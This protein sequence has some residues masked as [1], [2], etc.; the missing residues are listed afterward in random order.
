MQSNSG[1]IYAQVSFNQIKRNRRNFSHSTSCQ[2]LTNLSTGYAVF[3]HGAME[4]ADIS[5]Q[6]YNFPKTDYTTVEFLALE[7]WTSDDAKKKVQ[8]PLFSSPLFNFSYYY[9]NFSLFHFP[10]ITQTIAIS[11]K[12]SSHWRE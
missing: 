3:F 6:I 8:F 1:E 2:Q 10:I 5:K 4:I 9:H 12:M 7:I 11:A